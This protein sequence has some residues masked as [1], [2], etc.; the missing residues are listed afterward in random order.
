MTNFRD[1][2]PGDPI[3]WAVFHELFYSHR[4]ENKFGQFVRY[5][6]PGYATIRIKDY[7]FDSTVP[8]ED[9]YHA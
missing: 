9:L 7:A 1:F 5:A 8:T 3:R 2:K 6:H 4:W